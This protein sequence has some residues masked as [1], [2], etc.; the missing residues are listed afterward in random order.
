MTHQN[1]FQALTEEQTDSVTGAQEPDYSKVD[2]N[3]NLI[4]PDPRLEN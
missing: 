4:L 2:E 3:G 1:D